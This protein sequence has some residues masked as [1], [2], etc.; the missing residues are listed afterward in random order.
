MRWSKWSFWLLRASFSAAAYSAITLLPFTRFRD[1]LPSKPELYRYS[2][3]LAGVYCLKALG[4]LLIGGGVGA[5]YCVFGV[6]ALLYDAGFA[7]FLHW[8]FLSDFFS[9]SELDTDLLLYHEMHEAEF[10]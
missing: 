8:T 10:I 9:A 4:A 3:C 2:A 7:P 6:G 5:G 1:L